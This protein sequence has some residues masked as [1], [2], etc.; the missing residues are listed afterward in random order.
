MMS[1][2]YIKCEKL[3]NVQ[4]AYCTAFCNVHFIGEFVFVFAGKVGRFG[5]SGIV[6]C[7]CDTKQVIDQRKEIISYHNFQTNTTVPERM[8]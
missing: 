1:A 6:G 8:I 7:G 3:G 5:Y 2:R 4:A